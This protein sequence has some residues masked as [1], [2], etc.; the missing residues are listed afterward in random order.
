MGKRK[1]AYRFVR[2]FV[3]VPFLLFK[4]FHIPVEYSSSTASDLDDNQIPVK[5]AQ[6]YRTYGKTAELAEG[7]N[8]K[9]KK[10]II[11]EM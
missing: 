6:P 9:N 2:K 7:V 11:I 8:V 5:L 1:L 3:R 4:D 10:S